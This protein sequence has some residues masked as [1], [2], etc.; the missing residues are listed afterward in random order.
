MSEQLWYTWSTSGFGT[1][2]GF[3]VRAASANLTDIEGQRVRS[4]VNLARY[5]LSQDVDPFLSP[6][7]A[8]LCL[9]FLKTD[10][11]QESVLIQKTHSGPDGVGRPGAYFSHLVVNLP[12]VSSRSPA[13][14]VPFSAREAIALWKSPLW[15][16]KDSASTL[17]PGKRDLEQIPSAKLL[18]GTSVGPLT[19][20][21]VMQRQELFSLV[22]QAFLT[23]AVSGE[24]KRLYLGG[25]PDTVASLIWGITHAL[26]RTLN[27]MQEMTFSTFEA[28]LESDARPLIVG[29]C[30]L[31][32]RLKQGHEQALLDFPPQYYQSG[33]PYGIAINAASP[34]NHTP[35]VPASPIDAS[36][37]DKYVKFVLTCFSQ[38]SAGMIELN[39][40]LDEAEKRDVREMPAF[41][42][43]YVSFREK[44]PKEDVTRIL[45]EMAVK[46][47]AFGTRGEAILAQD[48]LDVLEMP[49][50]D[51]IT[52]AGE[53][54]KRDNVQRSLIHWM[55]QDASWWQSQG[56]PL[57]SRLYRL[58]Y[59]YNLDALATLRD[60]FVQRIVNSRAWRRKE[61]EDLVGALLPYV[62][63]RA[64][65]TPVEVL[66]VFANSVTT[67]MQEAQNELV[68]TLL[69]FTKKIIESVC[70]SIQRDDSRST[71]SWT[72]ILAICTERIS[73]QAHT[74]LLDQFS[75]LVYT[76]AYEQWWQ[77]YG[78]IMISRLYPVVRKRPGT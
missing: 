64:G 39:D 72:A 73:T 19:E 30:W 68:A 21:T 58:T 11:G 76:A 13:G 67:A 69:P 23:L 1:A 32:H 43:L 26:P 45:Q 15:K 55:T 74:Y 40:L 10:P 54:L 24:R 18:S 3:R 65:A 36:S 38:G 66:S 49:P 8:P 16:D 75:G 2:N 47:E 41:L 4:F 35:F 61:G 44:L 28:D 5:K 51:T 50:L 17:P 63:A 52:L 62:Q 70:L 6:Q 60:G 46:A 33:N 27:S 7:E 71:R 57:V 77:Q 37:I 53:I 9:A 25:D 14:Q 31:P 12:P 78:M 29:T 20:Q 42:H 34:Q 59:Q 56:Q 48:K 22:M